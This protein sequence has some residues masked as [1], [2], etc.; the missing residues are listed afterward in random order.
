MQNNVNGEK[1]AKKL[2]CNHSIAK[3]EKIVTSY[4]NRD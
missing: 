2:K 3:A 4:M 1:K